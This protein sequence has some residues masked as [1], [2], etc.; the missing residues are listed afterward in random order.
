MPAP[1]PDH[2]RTAILEDIKAG[3][4]SCRGI[5]RAHGVSDAAVRKL[6]KDHGIVDAFS[7]AQTENATRAVVAD[8]KARRA[9]LSRRLLDEAERSLDR[10]NRPYLVYAFG[11]RDN[12]YNEHLMDIPPAG[13]VRNLMTSAAV[14]ID[15]HAVLEKLDTDSGAA[16]A[17][18]MLGALAE[19]LQV[20]ADHI[21]GTT[22]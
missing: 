22:S 19:G 2:K 1:L 6:A 20:A 13:E 12:D 21:N 17:K 15:K 9:A 8:N 14:A 3:G 11:G 18:G 7:R 16:A 5:A 4:K 10:L